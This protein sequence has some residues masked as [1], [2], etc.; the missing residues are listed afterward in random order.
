MTYGFNIESLR[1]ALLIA[2][3]I[4]LALGTFLY[5]FVFR[6]L[7]TWYRKLYGQQIDTRSNVLLN[8]KLHRVLGFMAAAICLI[9]WWYL[10]T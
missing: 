9:L 1:L 3:V 10:A 6:P 7:L 2:A 5:P 8:E 4:A